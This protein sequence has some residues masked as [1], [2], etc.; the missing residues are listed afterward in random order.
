MAKQTITVFSP[1]AHARIAAALRAKSQPTLSDKRS[2]PAGMSRY[3]RVV[4][5]S[6]AAAPG[7]CFAEIVDIGV[8]GQT[9]I[10]DKPAALH[11]SMPNCVIVPW[12]IPAGGTGAGR[13]E[14]EAVDVDIA[15]LSGQ[16]LAVGMLV[17][18]LGDSWLG[19]ID[20]LGQWEVLGVTG[21]GT[22]PA[23]VTCRA[24]WVGETADNKIV[25]ADAVGGPQGAVKRIILS[26]DFT[27]DDAV[28]GA[29]GIA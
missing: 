29:P 20:P 12:L 21:A 17:A 25:D 2:Q 13:R 9:L 26:S 8:D 6:A 14:G 5:Q 23:T 28:F 3:W 16:T 22:G 15:V 24:I 10:V 19:H 27:V 4:N 7:R 11:H 1:T 18:M